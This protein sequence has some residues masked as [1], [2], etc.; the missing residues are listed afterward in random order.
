MALT[1][2]HVL[3]SSIVGFVAW[4]YLVH[5]L[6]ILRYLGYAFLSGVTLTILLLLT[7]IFTTSRA[8]QHGRSQ[9][10]APKSC[11]RFLHPETWQSETSSFRAERQYKAAP[12]YPSALLISNALD[13]LVTLALRDSISSWYSNITQDATFV[14]EIDRNI[15]LV[16]ADLRD[17]LLQKDLV[18]V[19]VSRIVPLVTAHL[20]DFDQAERSIRG[21]ALNRNV[22]ESEELDLAIAAKYRDGKLHPAASLTFSDTKLVQQEHLRKILERI[23]PDVLPENVVKS[24]AV[25]VLVKEIVACAVLFPLMQILADPDTWNQ[26]I[27]AYGRTALQDRK[28]VQKLRAALDQ[29]ASP[30][31]KSRHGPTFPRL[32]PGDNERSFERFVRAIRHTN[33]LSDVRRFRSHIASQLKRESMVDNQDQTYLRRLEIGKRLLDQKVIKLSGGVRS[34]STVP[35][36]GDRRIKNMAHSQNSTLV[37]ILKTSSGLS[38]FMEYMDRLNMMPLIQFWIVV[39]GFRNPLEDDFGDDATAADSLSWTETDRTDIAQ[40]NESYMSRP[41]LKVPDEMREAIRDFLRARRNATPTQ[42][43]RARTAILSTQSAILDEMETRYFPNFKKTDLFYKYLASDEASG[44]A[45]SQI[46]AEEFKSPHWERQGHLTDAP[47]MLQSTSQ[48]PA[49]S[50]DLRRAALSSTDLRTGPNL[51]EVP[52]DARKSLDTDRDRSAPLFDDDYDTDP[53][54]NSMHSFSKE[55]QNS[56]QVG[57]AAN[58]RRQVIENMEAALNDIVTASPK[59]DQMFESAQRLFGSPTSLERPSIFDEAP[60]GPLDRQRVET[61]NG[62]RVRPSIASLGLVNTSSRIGVFSDDDLFPDEEKFIEDEY[63]DSEDSGKEDA[64]EEEIHEAAPGD[65]GLVEAIAALTANIERLVSQESVVDTLTRKAELTNNAAELRILSKSKASLQREIRRKEL[66]RQQY[67][68]QES[69]NS[70][71]GRSSISIKSIMVGREDDGHEYALYVIEVQRKTGEQMPAASWVVARRYSEF[72]DLH[73]HLRSR[74]PSIRELDFPRRRVVMK[75]QKD[76]LHRR[77]VALEGYLR[78]LILLPEV[79]RSRELRSFLSQQAI[80]PH[81]THI[82]AD[83]NAKD[84]V[85]RIY[86]SVTDGMD[87]FLGNMAV[88]DQLSTAGQNLISAAT[89]QLSAT[90]PQPGTNPNHN[91][92]PTSTTTTI[93]ITEAEAELTAYEDRE[94]A[95]FIKPLCDLFLELFHLTEGSTSSTSSTSSTTTTTTTTTSTANWLRGRTVVIILHQLLGSTVERKVRDTIR[96]LLHPDALLRHIELVREMLWPAGG[97]GKLREVKER[98]TAERA[99]STAQA[100]LMLAALM[101]ELAAGVVG[102]GNALEAGRRVGA[103][104]DNQ[105]LNLHL[106]FAVLDEVVRVL[107]GAGGG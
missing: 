95:P 74:Y 35:R 87:D 6:P 55:S 105:R 41:E 4:G 79:C 82:P 43:R 53:L 63:A 98:S 38:Y 31:P 15:R 45:S 9:S 1:R 94:L 106:G 75:L 101:P 61:S 80:N 11:I 71:Y 21:Q 23:L 25:L 37:E 91:D 54:A 85:T 30:A 102:R 90:Y 47:P 96:S 68:V 40:I 19:A 20:R 52:R 44:S 73:H 14:N 60:V 62:E 33:N 10:A 49:R 76:F 104:M 70:L 8:A 16:V 83:P 51:L 65:L 3:L 69:D 84:M 56:D 34:A 17:R 26:L 103:M 18:D 107:F 12:L 28:T 48:P 93:S 46:E 7:I 81:Q 92:D 29:H 72:H 57:E 32:A 13:G 42:Y 64:E 67:I 88:L 97:G 66:Q 100:R 5:W 77:R 59:D 36:S 22:T 86:N 39:D 2:R 78:Q 27:E 24:R 50:R 89:T 58:E 99:R